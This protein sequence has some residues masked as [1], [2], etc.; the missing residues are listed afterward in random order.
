[1]VKE[2][3]DLCCACTYK[4]KCMDHGT[5]ENPKLFCEQFDSGEFTPHIRKKSDNGS[6]R[7]HRFDQANHSDE[8]GGLC[9]NCENRSNCTIARPEG[10]IWHCEEYR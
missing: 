1:V 7:S 3:L 10:H 8:V 4:A 9:A 2:Q 5:A 6:A